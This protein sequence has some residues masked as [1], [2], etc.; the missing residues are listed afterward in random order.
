MRKHKGSHGLLCARV[1]LS[2]C[3]IDMCVNCYALDLRFGAYARARID[4]KVDMGTLCN[5]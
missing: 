1:R 4:T 5:L 3:S 2:V